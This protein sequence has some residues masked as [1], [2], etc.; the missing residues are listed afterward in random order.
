MS[1]PSSISS[2]HPPASSTSTTRS[3][4]STSASSSS[5]GSAVKGRGGPKPPANIA[6]LARGRGSVGAIVRDQNEQKNSNQIDVND[7]HGLIN[8]GQN[9]RNERADDN[10]LDGVES[11]SRA[12]EKNQATPIAD[13]LLAVSLSGAIDLTGASDLRGEAYHDPAHCSSTVIERAHP[14]STSSSSTAFKIP[15]VPHQ[16]PHHSKQPTSSTMHIPASPILK[17]PQPDASR[18]SSD[19]RIQTPKTPVIRPLMM[20]SASN[21][22][23]RHPASSSTTM[24]ANKLKR[25]SLASRP[26]SST[27][28]SEQE[29]GIATGKPVDVGMGQRTSAGDGLG[30]QGFNVDA[31]NEPAGE[32]GGMINNGQGES[33][34]DGMLRSLTSPGRTPTSSRIRAIGMRSSISYSPRSST[35]GRSLLDE[36]ETAREDDSRRKG[37]RGSESQNGRT[38]GVIDG[39]RG[40]LFERDDG[41]GVMLD[42]EAGRVDPARSRAK[43]ETMADRWVKFVLIV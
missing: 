2:Y 24:T 23:D 32:N 37:R 36:L 33:E 3:T 6:R 21:I 28:S 34:P 4:T 27:L 13:R 7:T 41:L 5:A 10:D 35:P 22:P 31:R 26:L 9:S 40:V 25:L 29:Q 1:E 15:A 42:G 16:R 39:P 14:S 8:D 20:S 38:A 19:P 18:G 12:R 30:C 43:G 17:L 11:G